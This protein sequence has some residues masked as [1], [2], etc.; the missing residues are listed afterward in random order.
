MKQML[1]DFSNLLMVVLCDYVLGEANYL[2]LAGPG[3]VALSNATVHLGFQYLGVANATRRNVSVQLLEAS[4]N[5]TL[6][7]KHLPTNQAQGTLEF[8]CFHFRAAGDYW[9]ATAPDGTGS[10]GPAPTGRALLKAEWPAFRVALNRTSRA[11]GSAFQVGLFT[12]QPL[13]AF[14]A[15]KP[16]LLVDVV[17]T[18][19]RPEARAGPGPPLE[20]RAR[21]RTQLSAGQWVEFGCAPVGPEARVTVVLRLFGRD[22]VI[23]AS[24]PVGLAQRFGYELVLAPEVTC[25]SS[26]EVAVLPPPCIP[27]HGVV[28]V[29]KEAPGRPGE[30]R[31]RLAERGLALG[32]RTAVFSCALFDVGRNKYC[33]SFGAARGSQVPPKDADCTLIQRNIETWG[34]WQPWSQCSATCGDGVRERRRTCLSPFPSR[35]GCPGTPSEASPCSLEDCAALRPSSPRPRPPPRP[36]K[37]SDVVPV[38]GISL[39]LCVVAAT[40]L[41]ALWRRLGRTPAC[42]APARPGSLGAPG[43][44]KNSDEENI[45][46]PSERRGSSSDA[47][48]GPGGAG[49]PLTCRR[50]ED[51]G[52]PGAQR[53]APPLF[54]YRLAQQQLKE[55]RRRGLTE[56]T[57]LYRVSRGP[58]ADTAEGAPFRRTA[59]LHEARR[60]RPFRERSLSSLGPRARDAAEDGPPG[61][62]AAAGSERGRPLAPGPRAGACQARRGRRRSFPARPGPAFYDNSSFGLPDAGR[63]APG[64]PGPPEEAAAGSALGTERLGI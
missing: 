23:T 25:E 38:A 3:H 1:K 27:V 10:G 43:C 45:C 55:M 33:F 30:R 49:I 56:A 59:S 16:D 53:I 2:L 63:R 31:A 5:Q 64:P 51:D 42:G 57:T 11:A 4:T 36:A 44:R 54:S 41:L 35:P 19:S 7:T 47:G 50:P 52:P 58:R 29:F 40:V 20:V 46:E 34:L 28:A 60:P 39:C 13:C 12:S 8:E 22:S 6:A 15:D 21:R 24:G 18:D 17:L 37:S 9:F 48:E 26:L 14:P 61:A 62:G 32:E